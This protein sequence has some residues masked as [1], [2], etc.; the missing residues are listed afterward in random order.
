[1]ITRRV[2]WDGWHKHK[3][4]INEEP[5]YA[6]F[7]LPEM[8]DYKPEAGDA[9]TKVIQLALDRRKSC[10]DAE[11]KTRSQADDDLRFSSGDQWPEAI[12]R[13]RETDPNGERPCLTI[14]KTGQFVRQV[15]N[16]ARQNS[17]AIRAFPIG[18]GADKKRAEILNGI[19]RDISQRTD[20]DIAYET[21]IESTARVGEGYFRLISR[22]TSEEMGFDQELAF[23]RIRNYATVHIDPSAIDPAGADAGFAFV[24]EW[25][26]EKEFTNQYG[27]EKMAGLDAS[28][29]GEYEPHW[30]NGGNILVADYYSVEEDQKL[31]LAMLKDGNQVIL[32][33]VADSVPEEDIVMQ[34]GIKTARCIIR[35]ITGS[36]VLEK[37]V[38]MSRYIPVFRVIGEEFEVDGDVIYQGLIRPMK[39]SARMYNYWVTNATEKGALESK[40]PYIGAEGQFE[41][42]E[43]QWKVANKVPFAYLEYKPVDIDGNLAPP[44]QRSATTFAGAAD[45]EMAKLA[46]EDMKS[47]AGIYDPG[48]GA[49]SNEKSGKA[50]IA[51][52]RESDTGTFHYVGNLSRAIRHCGRVLVEV[53]PK[54]INKDQMVRILGEDDSEEMMRVNYKEEKDGVMQTI[55]D[56]TVGRY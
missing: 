49:Q 30:V 47:T 28:G 37:T 18:D 26:P 8:N 42:H 48:L 5:H 4:K 15:V 10:V 53:L 43:H 1:M 21:A 38:W 23:Q 27:E 24:D 9:E 12:R 2:V 55:N 3:N 36:S 19:I 35:K 20:A 54:Y 45:I 50:I 51:R 25:M 13:S 22:Y 34:R 44:P 32:E 41:G 39:D 6:A 11:S 40:A 33:E 46:A 52:Q 14:D 56:I 17:P 16:D 31:T 29:L 7:L